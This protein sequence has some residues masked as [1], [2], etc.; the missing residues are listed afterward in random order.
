MQPHLE[1]CLGKRLSSACLHA[2]KAYLTMFARELQQR[3]RDEGSTIDVMQ[4]HP[5]I[6]STDIFRQ[7]WLSAQ[8]APGCS[9]TGHLIGF[10]HGGVQPGDTGSRLVLS[11][12]L[13]SA[14]LLLTCR[15]LP[16]CLWNCAICVC[17]CAQHR[18]PCACRKED[19][20]KPTA[21]LLDLLGNR[22][23]AQ[24]QP[25]K[26]AAH[27]VLY[28]ATDPTL[29]GGDAWHIAQ[30]IGNA[31]HKPV[32]R[33]LESPGALRASHFWKMDSLVRVKL[34]VVV[35]RASTRT[36]LSGCRQRW[37]IEALWTHLLG[38]PYCTPGSDA[39][40]EQYRLV[41]APK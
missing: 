40:F 16:A 2:G 30:Q 12:T 10:A 29:T 9:R 26:R 34:H 3:L 22:F 24:W 32:P 21:V 18:L 27:A 33:G 31:E 1:P 36:P 37:G 15:D 8:S 11:Q 38:A 23:L 14:A 41:R 6:S 4:A 20:H 5:G 13:A 17:P 35:R 19:K 25:P 28:A 39:E 7:V